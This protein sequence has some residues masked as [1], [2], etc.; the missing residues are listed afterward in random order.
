MRD[1][2]LYLLKFEVSG[3]YG[4]LMADRPVIPLSY[5]ER[6]KIQVPTE[7]SLTLPFHK[8]MSAKPAEGVFYS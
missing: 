1:S 6:Q 8:V 7:Q 3:T 4:H 2:K 5:S